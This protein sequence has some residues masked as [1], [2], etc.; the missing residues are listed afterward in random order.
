MVS[1]TRRTLEIAVVNDNCV[2]A[3]HITFPC[4]IKIAHVCGLCSKNYRAVEF[5]VLKPCRILLSG[6]QIMSKSLSLLEETCFVLK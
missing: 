5:E 2:I 1:L 6:L 4:N 3:H